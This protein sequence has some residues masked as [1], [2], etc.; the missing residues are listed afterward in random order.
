MNIR[1]PETVCGSCRIKCLC[2][3]LTFQHAWPA[4][5]G[6]AGGG[7]P[8]S[9]RSAPPVAGAGPDTRMSTGR[10]RVAQSLPEP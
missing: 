9:G 3:T 1:A 5:G 4:R 10:A 2:P 7:F 6:D 8:G